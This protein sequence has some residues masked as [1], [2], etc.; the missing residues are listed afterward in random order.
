MNK[1]FC[2]PRL[3][4]TSSARIQK[5]LALLNDYVFQV[6]WYSNAPEKDILDGKFVSCTDSSCGIKRL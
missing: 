1:S 6:P 3:T 2:G 4:A 5:K